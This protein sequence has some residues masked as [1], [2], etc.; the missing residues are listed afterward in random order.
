MSVLGGHEGNIIEKGTFELALEG[1]L[2]FHRMGSAIP[3]ERNKLKK[4]QS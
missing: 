4:N 1:L 3:S 2:G